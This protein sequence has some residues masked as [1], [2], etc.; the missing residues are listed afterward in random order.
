M[1]FHTPVLHGMVAVIAWT[2]FSFDLPL[3]TGSIRMLPPVTGSIRMLPPVTGSVRTLPPVTGNVRTPPLVT[4][5]VRTPPLVTGNV[6]T[7][8]LVTGSVRTL[9]PVTGSVRKGLAIRLTDESGEE[10]WGEIAPLPGRSKETLDQAYDQLLQI[11]SKG[12]I[13]EEPL[14]SVQFGLEG[15]LSDR[16]DITA[17]LYALLHGTAEEILQRA[18]EVFA[19]GYKTVKVKISS[20]SVDEATLLIHALKDRFRLR[21]DCNRAFSMTQALRL[22]SPFDPKQF[23]YI[24]DPTFE[25]EKLADFPF[26]FA[27]DEIV[28]DYHLLPLKSYQHLYGFI[29]KPT[30][31]GGKKGC[32]P[33]V[34]YAQEHNLNVVFS[35]TFESGLGL[36]HILHIAAH[37]NLLAHPVGIDTHRYLAHDILHHDIDFKTPIIK[38]TPSL[39][40][41][42]ERLKEVAHGKCA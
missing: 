27:L 2:I 19:S 34:K 40:V 42:T 28:T 1:D 23:D 33:F 16:S 26:P 22:F 25:I 31:L 29:L 12:K 32:A 24:E 10:R 21:I 9:P 35:S 3:V 41:N 38:I 8:P 18:E 30:L 17:P 37:F 20:F 4:G 14:P 7:L 15:A 39:K 11:F 36:L 6:C 5:N 13:Q